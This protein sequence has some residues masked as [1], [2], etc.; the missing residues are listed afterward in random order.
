VIVWPCAHCTA[1]RSERGAAVG[2][3]IWDIG[4]AVGVRRLGHGH[5]HQT[6][7]TDSS[8]DSPIGRSSPNS[9]LSRIGYA[10]ENPSKSGHPVSWP[11][12][13]LVAIFIAAGGLCPGVTV[14]EWAP[15]CRVHMVS[16]GHPSNDNSLVRRR[17][18]R[19]AKQPNECWAGAYARRCERTWRSVPRCSARARACARLLKRHSVVVFV[20]V[21][22]GDAVE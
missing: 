8:D 6:Y 7:A 2:D 12:R 13:E 3:T 14:G 5:G 16:P 11:R 18:K 1:L 20:D 10:P 4:R 21:G 19:R 17:M 9:L 22:G 15:R